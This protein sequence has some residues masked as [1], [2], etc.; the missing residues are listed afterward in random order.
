MD[1][2]CSIFFLIIFY[3]FLIFV[4]F[5]DFLVNFKTFFTLIL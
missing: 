2:E 1:F 3:V 5:I 4:L